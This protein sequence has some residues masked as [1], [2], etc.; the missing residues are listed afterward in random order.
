MMEDI[1][2]RVRELEDRIRI[3][4]MDRIRISEG[5]QRKWGRRKFRERRNDNF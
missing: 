1:P 5:E 3:F 4:K 2:E